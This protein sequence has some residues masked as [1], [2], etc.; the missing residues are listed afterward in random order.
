[1]VGG[2][3]GAG[4]EEG[5]ES[6]KVVYLEFKFVKSAGPNCFKTFTHII[7][8]GLLLINEHPHI[9]VLRL[10]PNHQSVP[11]GPTQ[12][13]CIIT[14]VDRR[15]LSILDELVLQPLEKMDPPPRAESQSQQI[16]PILVSEE[17]KAAGGAVLGHGV[18][19]VELLGGLVD[20]EQLVVD[21]AEEQG[22]G[23]HIVEGCDV[24]AGLEAATQLELPLAHPGGGGELP[25]GGGGEVGGDEGAVPLYIQQAVSSH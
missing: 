6:A 9:E 12:S 5:A 18:D 15:S 22:V 14:E 19:G 2:A 11:P 16:P 25:R 13:L 20:A 7:S 4:G 24:L 21:K 8:F 3:L 23:F 17:G 1:M 10:H